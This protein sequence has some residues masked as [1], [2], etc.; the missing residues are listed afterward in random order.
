MAPARLFD[1]TASHSWTST[2]DNEGK[3][4]AAA[5][6]AAEGEAASARPLMD[7]RPPFFLERGFLTF[8]FASSSGSNGGTSRDATRTL[9]L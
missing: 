7:T 1:I 4:A 5:A 2:S 8:F 9:G 6:A 3:A